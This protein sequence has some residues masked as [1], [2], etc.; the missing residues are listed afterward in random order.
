MNEKIVEINSFL[1]YQFEQKG[2]S[3]ILLE[4]DD[5]GGL[6]PCFGD[7][8]PFERSEGKVIAEWKQGDKVRFVYKLATVVWENP[9]TDDKVYCGDDVRYPLI[10]MGER[11][12]DK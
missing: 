10:E 6:D 8:K 7:R 1:H 5:E 9:I 4:Y 2:D 11:N 3:V 12:W